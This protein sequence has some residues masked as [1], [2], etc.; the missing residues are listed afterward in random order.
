[1]TKCM[2][3]GI[4]LDAPHKLCE[5]CFKLKHYNTLINK[6]VSIDNEEI[7][8]KINKLNNYVFFLVDFLNI[9]SEVINIYKK[10]KCEKV[11]VVTKCDIIPKNIIYDKLKSNIKNVYNIDEDV[12]L[13]SSK[14]NYNISKLRNKSLCKKKVLF[15]GFTNAGKSSLI[16][17]LFASDVTVSSKSNTTQDF[18]KIKY[19]DIIVYDT[20]GF[21]SK[22]IREVIPKSNLKPKTCKLK[23]DYTL[24]FLDYELNTNIDTNI[25]IYMN[26]DI[27]S[28]KKNSDIT[29]NMSIPSNSDLVIKGIGFISFK[30]SSTINI[31][32]DVEVRKSIVGGNYE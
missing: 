7:I 16:N 28:K 6:G 32:G 15:T 21:I 13:V 12:I 30:N 19:E 26:I 10:I 18:I 27:K 2:G 17:K 9:D 5:R 22:T 25:T 4:N 14:N 3:C 23:H 20:P 31:N 8:K 1:M 11:L 29:C 24:N